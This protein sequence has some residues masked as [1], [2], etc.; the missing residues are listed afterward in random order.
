M[1]TLGGGGHVKMEAETGA[2]LLQAEKHLEPLD[3]GR[4]EDDFPLEPLEKW[5]SC[6]HLDFRFP[7][8]RTVRE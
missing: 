5:W 6:G 7:A 3:G 4:G 8:S 1:Q 2:L